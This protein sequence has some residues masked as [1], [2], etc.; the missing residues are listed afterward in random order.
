MSKKLKRFC[1][2]EDRKISNG[3]KFDVTIMSMS[4][5]F[6]VT[7]SDSTLLHKKELYDFGVS[8]CEIYY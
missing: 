3:T 6:K 7:F 4:T 1:C 5:R 2:R 8:I